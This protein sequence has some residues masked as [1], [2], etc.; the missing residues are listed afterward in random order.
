MAK[1]GSE[2]KTIHTNISIKHRLYPLLLICRLQI[3][4]INIQQAT[5]TV[6][7][8]PQSNFCTNKLLSIYS[9]EKKSVSQ[10]GPAKMLQVLI[11]FSLPLLL[12]AILQ[13]FVMWRESNHDPFSLIFWN[14]TLFRDPL[15]L[16][17]G[18]RERKYRIWHTQETFSMLYWKVLEIKS[19]SEHINR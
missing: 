15:L 12:H 3:I 2:H 16:H 18:I 1:C 13:N 19:K 11:Q 10:R 4:A 17:T 7:L 9:T 6:P 5:F 8:F 14:T